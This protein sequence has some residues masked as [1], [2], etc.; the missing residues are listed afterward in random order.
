MNGSALSVNWAKQHADAIIEAWY[1]GEDGGT[2]IAETLAGE[3]NPAG[4]LPVTFYKGLSDLPAFDDYR[5]QGRTYRYYSGE[6]LFPFG[7]GLSYTTFSYSDLRLSARQLT[8]GKPLTATV[9]VKNS[10]TREGDEAVE[11]M[12]AHR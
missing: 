11:Q 4:R 12:A 8:A 5:M 2:A 10:G 6:P 7:F 9:K 1:P 3:N